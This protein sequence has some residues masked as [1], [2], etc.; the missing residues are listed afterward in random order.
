MDLYNVL[1]GDKIKAKCKFGEIETTVTKINKFTVSTDCGMTFKKN[2]GESYVIHYNV[3]E[4]VKPRNTYQMKDLI[5]KYG[6]ISGATVVP[7]RLMELIGN[8]AKESR[9]QSQLRPDQQVVIEIDRWM[10]VSIGRPLTQYCDYETNK[11]ILTTEDH[12]ELRVLQ[13]LDVVELIELPEHL[14]ESE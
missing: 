9:W 12:D 6:D 3:T 8:E 2:S 14:K 7:V 1:V 11:N 4:V 5:D 13:A 10:T